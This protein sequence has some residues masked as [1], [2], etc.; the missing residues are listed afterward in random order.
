[1][2]GVA[3]PHLFGDVSCVIGV[4]GAPCTRRSFFFI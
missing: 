2:P 3:Y 1:M 4:F